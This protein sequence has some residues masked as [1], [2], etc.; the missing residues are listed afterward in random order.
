MSPMN[1]RKNVH[2]N[3]L[4]I[5]RLFRLFNDFNSLLFRLYNS[6][7]QIELNLN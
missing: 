2:Q 6:T 4:I 7:K 1:I 3:S 5:K